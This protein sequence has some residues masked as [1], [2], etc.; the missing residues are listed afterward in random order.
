MS[1]SAKEQRARAAAF[2]GLVAALLAAS[3]VP[4]QEAGVVARDAWVRKPAP[5]KH[6]AALFV[7]VENHTAQKRKIIGV[8]T[9]AASVA[10]MHEMRMEKMTMSMIPISELSIPAHG[11]TTLNPDR[12]HIMLFGLKTR[13]A[14]GDVINATLKLDDGT[15]VPV[16]ATV[17]K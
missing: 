2:A 13:P 11:K 15:T 4:A 1:F 16:T 7:V 17:R 3:A 12:Y 9:D 10:E 5:S 8:T 14:I 6:D